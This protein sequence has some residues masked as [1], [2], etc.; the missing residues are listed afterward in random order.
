M[1]VEEFAMPSPFPGM[2]PY[3]ESPAVWHGFHR[4][5]IPA[6][7]NALTA[8]LRPNYIVLIEEQIYVHEIEEQ[9][10]SLA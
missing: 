8:Q 2:N 10:R 9:S 7:A 4:R 1:L 3:L 5:F 6:I